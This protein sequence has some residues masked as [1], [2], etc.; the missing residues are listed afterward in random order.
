MSAL[1]DAMRCELDGLEPQRWFSYGVT[2]IQ[3]GPPFTPNNYVQRE[4]GAFLV[5]AVVAWRLASNQA[6][7]VVS[8][9]N[10][11]EVFLTS[12][13]RVELMKVLQ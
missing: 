3:I 4:P 12:K 9:C 7:Y 8:L 13:E 10:G 11:N 2:A 5:A 6:Y 1:Q